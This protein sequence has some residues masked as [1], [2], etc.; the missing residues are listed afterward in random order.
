MSIIEQEMINII[1]YIIECKFNDFENDF[2]NSDFDEAILKNN[3]TAIIRTESIN[4]LNM[5]YETKI[6]GRY[7]DRNESRNI[8]SQIVKQLKQEQNRTEHIK[9][10]S[11]L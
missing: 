7:K 1:Y 6:I 2:R 11:N 8:F 3:H 5:F 9:S 4:S 10:K